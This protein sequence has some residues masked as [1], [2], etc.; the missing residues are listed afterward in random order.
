MTKL[1]KYIKTVLGTE[2]EIN[3]F[4]REHQK[5]LPFYLRELY[6]INI[7]RLLNKEVLFLEQTGTENLTIEQYR[8]QIEIIENAFKLPAV[9]I[10]EHLEPY[11]RKRLIEKQIAFIHTGKQMYIPRLFVDL[12]EFREQNNN[13]SGKLIPAAQALLFFHLLNDNLTGM[14]FK[15]VAEKT[16]YAQMTITRAAKNLFENRLCEIEGIKEKKIIFNDY[17]QMLWEKSKPFLQNPI[18]RKKYF[19]GNIDENLIYT[20]GYPA[21]AFYTN[22]SGGNETCFAI[23]TIDYNYLFKNKKLNLIDKYSGAYILEVWKYPPALTANNN[24]VDPL[25]L[26]VIFKDDPDERVQM[27]I[28]ILISKLW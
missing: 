21:L 20:A 3:R 17:K 14:N 11:Q 22:L 28:E 6:E 9:L 13:T 25:S 24:L 23:S 27:E 2:P 10:F 4:P 26:Y 19:E 12:R 5:V 8:K 16:N 7:V 1:Q 15:A 18:K